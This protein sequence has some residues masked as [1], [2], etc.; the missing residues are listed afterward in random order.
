MRGFLGK[1]DLSRKHISEHEKHLIII[2]LCVVQI[3]IIMWSKEISKL[4]ENNCLLLHGQRR[5]LIIGTKINGTKWLWAPDSHRSFPGPHFDLAIIPLI[6]GMERIIVSDQDCSLSVSSIFLGSL[7]P[8]LSHEAD[9]H[10]SPH[11]VS[12]MPALFRFSEHI[13]KNL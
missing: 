9:L 1:L 4:P 12:L 10:A 7:K 6:S 8:K 3:F 5:V 13:S 11:F 2:F